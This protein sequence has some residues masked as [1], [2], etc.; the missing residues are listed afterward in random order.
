MSEN[1]LMEHKVSLRAHHLLCIQFF[2]GI[3]YNAPFAENMVNI[4][5]QLRENPEVILTR[6][7]DDVCR[8]CPNLQ[9]G[10]CLSCEKVNG[11]D[12]M[13]EKLCTLTSGNV[14]FWKELVYRVKEEVIRKNLRRTVCADCQWDAVCR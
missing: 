9:S 5:E 14:Y 11:Y 3:G 4:V 6:G 7:A 1:S 2:K 10:K 12:C 8:A 13:V